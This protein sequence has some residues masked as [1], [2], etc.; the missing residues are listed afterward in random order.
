LNNIDAEKKKYLNSH[1]LNSYSAAASSN[2]LPPAP[3]KEALKK[4]PCKERNILLGQQAQKKKGPPVELNLTQHMNLA[5]FENKARLEQALE[6]AKTNNQK[7]KTSNVNSS[8]INIQ[9]SN[10]N[11][12]NV[13]SVS[14]LVIIPKNP[15][16]PLATTSKVIFIFIQ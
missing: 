11:N 10:S 6:E 1:K 15:E 8:N 14:K 9:Y 16:Q 4:L 12:R 2:K 3:Y 7:S 13:N 5:K